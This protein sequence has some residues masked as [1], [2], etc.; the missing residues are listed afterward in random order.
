MVQAAGNRDSIKASLIAKAD[1]I[2]AQWDELPVVFE[3]ATK[4][5][6]A[7]QKLGDTENVT[8]VKFRADGVSMDKI[9]PF[10]DD[11]LPTIAGIND[12]ISYTALGE[13]EGNKLYHL[14][15]KMPTLITNRSIIT[16]FYKEE[17]ADGSTKIFHSSQGNEE[18]LAANAAAVGKDV[19][20][21]VHIAYWHIKPYDGGVEL[22]WT[23]SIN[24][25]GMIPGFV[26][27]KMAKRGANS[28]LHFVAYLVDG[29]KPEPM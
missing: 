12:K 9:Q 14:K 10:I 8:A 13:V 19:I 1:S 20:A 27:N 6:V 23:N 25:N 2:F 4:N 17:C 7:K 3:D 28:M 5:Y 22:N 18:Q 15:M 24:P 26:V 11:P 29:I 21:T 16:C